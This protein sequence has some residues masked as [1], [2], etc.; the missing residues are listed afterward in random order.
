MS[1]L[2]FVELARRILTPPRAERIKGNLIQ[3][4]KADRCGET[5]PLNSDVHVSYDHPEPKSGQG[6]VG[7]P[8]IHGIAL[9]G[10]GLDT[11]AQ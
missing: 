10:V 7:K 1:S 5:T 4:N 8:L 11:A 3:E 2:R 9:K 6:E